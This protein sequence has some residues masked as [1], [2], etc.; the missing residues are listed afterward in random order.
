M[1][2]STG[3]R[4]KMWAWIGGAVLLVGVVGIVIAALSGS[5]STPTP[6]PSDPRTPSN[7]SSSSPSS[8][9]QAIVDPDV[10]DRGWAPEPITTDAETYVA[11]ALAAASTFDTKASARDEWLDYLETWFTPDTRY[12]EGQDRERQLSAALTELRQGVV[13]PEQEW[14]SLAAEDGRVEATAGAVSLSEVP[15]DATGDMAIGTA[16]VVLTFTRSDGAGGES[17]YEESVRVSVQVLCGEES[18][19][20]PNSAQRAGDC[21]VVR[22]FTEPVEP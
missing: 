18:V 4:A 5:G 9:G 1:A 16:D 8:N 17:S 12:P 2:R 3:G 20:T 22:F 15:E 11:A 10:V 6:S 21:K 14:Q 19:P 7:G 13:L